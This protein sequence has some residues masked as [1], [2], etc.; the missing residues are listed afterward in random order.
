LDILFEKYYRK[1][2]TVSLTFQ[3]NLLDEIDWNNR[4]IGIKGA[5]GA[6]KTTLLF[7]YIHLHKLTGNNQTLYASLDDLYFTENKLVALADKFVKEGGK[8]LLL[9]EVHRYT[10]WSQEIKN[11]YDDHAEL[12]IIFTGSSLIH[13]EK[14]KADLSRRAVMYELFGLSF[15]EYL[16]F[17]TGA[18][19]DKITLEGLLLN[20]TAHAR[21]IA[22]EIKPL[23]YIKKYLQNGYYPFF[24]EN[25]NTYY[26][27]LNETISLALN[28]DLPSAYGMNYGSIEKIR[29][30]LYI[31][32][33]SAP[34]K[35][36]ISKLSERVGVSR[37][38]LLEFLRYLE[39]MRIARRLYASTKGIGLLQKPEK[40][41]LYHPNLHY[42]LSFGNSNMGNIRE[43]FFLSQAM[44]VMNMVYTNEGD[45]KS[46]KYTFEIGGKTKNNSQIKTVK[47]AF[48]VGDDIEIGR[49]NKIPLWLFGFLY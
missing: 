32:A 1:L 26:Q 23:A 17:T 10:N 46:G 6:G 40:L 27:K 31:L 30:L 35:P 9:D 24:I 44:P 12:Q 22:K 34:F 47:D 4:L 14:A 25:E 48:I 41:Y 29:L 15:R 5:R 39:E 13:L 38:S 37:N 43:S 19:F 42:A 8:Y 36:N 49:N 11:I 20:H 33:E 45:F 28:I 7:Q 2:D 21:K 16:N 18:S 3:R